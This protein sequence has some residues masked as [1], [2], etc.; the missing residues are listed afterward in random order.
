MKYYLALSLTIVCSV[1]MAAATA[2][3]VEETA[4]SK[5]DVIIPVTDV[6]I[7]GSRAL[8]TIPDNARHLKNRAESAP[9]FA[10]KPFRENASE[11]CPTT[12]SSEINK[13]IKSFDVF[14]QSARVL[15]EFQDPRMAEEAM[16]QSCVVV[17][18]D[19][20]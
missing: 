20:V 13:T 18:N 1:L 2:H 7:I 9:Y 11:D 17:K 4:F 10:L 15:V 19:R 3:A 8:M 16:R 14:E 5:A 12:S 6:E